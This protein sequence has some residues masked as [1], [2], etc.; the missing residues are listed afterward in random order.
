MVDADTTEE[1]SSTFMGSGDGLVT[2][3]GELLEAV[4]ASLGTL[5]VTTCGIGWRRVVACCRTRGNSGWTATERVCGVLE[6]NVIS[7]GSV[8]MDGNPEYPCRDQE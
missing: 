8:I 3:V 7:E 5:L 6:G 1:S 4:G 2:L